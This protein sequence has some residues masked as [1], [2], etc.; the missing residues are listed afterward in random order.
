[1]QQTQ[2]LHDT[3]YKLYG[4]YQLTTNRNDPSY[5][6]WISGKLKKINTD[7]YFFSDFKEKPFID[8]YFM[9]VDPSVT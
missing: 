3:S 9:K 4:H 2:T 8:Q 7:E 5:R 1:M 6:N